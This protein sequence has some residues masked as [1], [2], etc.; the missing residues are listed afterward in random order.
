MV[1]FG[2]DV[3]KNMTP[4]IMNLLNKEYA[5]LKKNIIIGR[6]F[7]N[8]EEIKKEIDE[9]TNLIYYPNAEK[10]KEV[11]LNSDIAISA[12]GQTLHELA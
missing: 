12:G 1:T 7:D 6:A 8:I 2:R 9:N 5:A 3:A 10:I 4:N 11:M